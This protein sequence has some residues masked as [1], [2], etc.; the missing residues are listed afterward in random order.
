MAYIMA[1]TRE[2]DEIEQKNEKVVIN[3]LHLAYCESETYSQDTI[4]LALNYNTGILFAPADVTED[5]FVG[6]SKTLLYPNIIRKENESFEITAIIGNKDGEV[7][8]KY[9]NKCFSVITKDFIHF[10][11]ISWIDNNNSTLEEMNRQTGFLKKKIRYHDMVNGQIREEIVK[12]SNILQITTKELDLLK[13]RYGDTWSDEL[14]H[15]KMTGDQLYSAFQI[16]NYADPIVRYNPDNHKYYFM[17]TT[18]ID[19]NTTLTIR[20][21]NQM[22]DLMKAPAV[23][24]RGKD[25]YSYEI[26]VNQ[27]ERKLLLWAP[28]LHKI[29]KFWYC[30][31]TSG[32]EEWFCQSSYIMRNKTGNLLDSNAWEKPMLCKKKDGI[33]KLYEEG[34]TLDMTYFQDGDKDYVVWAQRETPQCGGRGLGNSVLYLATIEQETPS[35][36][37]CD[38]VKIAQPE[39]GW[40]KRTTDVLE[41][42]FAIKKGDYIY[43][44]YSASGV[45]TTY[46]VGCLVARS[47]SDLQDPQSWEKLM[48]PILTTENGGEKGPGHCSF[49]IDE[50]GNEILVYHFFPGS[51]RSRSTRARQLR[52]SSIGIPVLN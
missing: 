23:P 35:I 6:E 42:P 44:V 46:C 26:G 22:M 17:A 47:G 9:S 37:S 34:I 24:L 21:A 41:G 36:I 12:Y 31:F 11:A 16:D 13:M 40:E 5:S 19:G 38:P 49:C 3:S 25:G 39:Y 29:G 7:D 10:S 32:G 45:D 50:K 33:T 48:S 28:E 52:W 51:Y 43:L 2:K 14:K 18:G 4:F 27:D 15:G 8:L 30:L 20:E 1:Y